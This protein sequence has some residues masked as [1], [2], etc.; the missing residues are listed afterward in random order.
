MSSNT[1]HSILVSVIII[2][3]AIIFQA[4]SSRYEIDAS[5]PYAWKLDRLT[6]QVYVCDHGRCMKLPS[7]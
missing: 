3:V 6:G 2:T 1:A 5:T 4:F 7:D